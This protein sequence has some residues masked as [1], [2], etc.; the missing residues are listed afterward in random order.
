MEPWVI[1]MEPDEPIPTI[2]YI[3]LSVILV[4][5]DHSRE[6]QTNFAYCLR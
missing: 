4:S 6:G 2:E 3:M 1:L 5:E